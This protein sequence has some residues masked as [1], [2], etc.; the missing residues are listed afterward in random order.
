MPSTTLNGHKHHWEEFGQGDPL[1]MFHGA[2][3]SSVT[4]L[5]YA[6]ELAATHRVIVPDL[7]G[8]GQSAHVDQITPPSGW[9]DD[10]VALLDHLGIAKAHVFGV[11]LGARIA[12][13][14]AI[15]H[16]QRVR[17]LIMELPIIAIDAAGSAS[18]NARIGSFDDLPL[19]DQQ[20]REAQHGPEWRT[21]L[22]NYMAIRNRQDLQDHLDLRAP[23]KKVAAPTLII[24]GDEREVVHPMSHSMQLYDNIAGSWL[25]VRSNTNGSV[26]RAAPQETYAQM[27]AIMAKG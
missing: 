18:L 3:G 8:M 5:P 10:A 16:P 6:K 2:A 22:A 19:A 11:S 17:T 9:T 25:W 4:L 1:I 24:R 26:M 20:A 14:V 21:V 27:R 7:R 12:L 13:R 23:S 15:D